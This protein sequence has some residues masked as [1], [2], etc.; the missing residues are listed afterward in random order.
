[1]KVHFVFGEKHFT[2]D[3]NAPRDLSVAHGPDGVTG[4]YAPPLELKPVVEDGFIGSVEQGGS[5]NF[6]Y[7]TF[8]PHAH[9]T[10]TECVGH[11]S[12]EMISVNRSLDRYFYPALLL[13]LE[14]ESEGEDLVL[15]EA[16]LADLPAAHCPEALIIRTRGYRLAK[17]FTG[18]NFPYFSEAAMK[19]I[20]HSGVRHLLVDMPSVDRERDGGLLLA[21]RAFW[22]GRER[23]GCTITELIRV[24]DDVP[25]GMYLLNLQVAPLENDAAPSRPLIF[26]VIEAQ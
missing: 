17:D 14:P 11:L 20:A 21:H 10:H 8:S 2:A 23:E 25:D 13:T 22:H 19:K 26:P 15:T 12:R 24:P 7:V 9:G 6:R 1:M 18:T 3:L 5:V 16:A 4:W